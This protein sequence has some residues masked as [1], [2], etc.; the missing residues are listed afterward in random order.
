[1]VEQHQV[2]GVVKVGNC[3][4]QQPLLGGVVVGKKEDMRMTLEDMIKMLEA[5]NE[6]G[7]SK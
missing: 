1:M 6:S 2:W 7:G 4:C 3:L 5:A